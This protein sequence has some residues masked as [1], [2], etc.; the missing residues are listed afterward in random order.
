MPLKAGGEVGGF[1]RLN[2]LMAPLVPSLAAQL[3]VMS[4]VGTKHDRLFGEMPLPSIC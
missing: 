2:N 3:T 1:A 4:L